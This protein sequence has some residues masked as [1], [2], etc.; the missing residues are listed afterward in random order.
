MEMEFKAAYA[1]AVAIMERFTVQ[2]KM[3]WS[4]APTATL[5]AEVILEA[6]KAPSAK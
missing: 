3:R 5:L 1:L 6:Q 4:G 2:P